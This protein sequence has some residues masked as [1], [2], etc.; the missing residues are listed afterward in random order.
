V[1]AVGFGGWAVQLGQ[2]ASDSRQAADVA[3]SQRAKL[4]SL[5]S[6]DDVQTVSGKFIS[7]DNAG[8]VVM[9]EKRQMA[10]F[11]ASSVP[12]LPEGKVYEAWTVKG[13]PTPAGIF[14]SD[15]SDAVVELSDAAFEADS[16]AVTIE[17]EGGSPKPTGDAVFNVVMP[18]S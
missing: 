17:P 13:D 14:T 2:D 4:T 10:L 15:D 1:A 11:V 12:K 8:A 6:A 3:L 16:I 5:L 9:S 7:N 18:K